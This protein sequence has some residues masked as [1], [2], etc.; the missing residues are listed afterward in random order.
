MNVAPVFYL[1]FRISR[2]NQIRSY[3]S[4]KTKYLRC[5]MRVVPQMTFHNKQ[6]FR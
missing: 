6:Y 5:H 1:C 2:E 3:R 4:R